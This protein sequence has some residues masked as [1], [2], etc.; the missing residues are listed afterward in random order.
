[1]LSASYCYSYDKELK[2]PCKE[3]STKIIPISQLKAPKPP[4]KISDNLNKTGI[5]FQSSYFYLNTPLQTLLLRKRELQEFLEDPLQKP[6][7]HQGLSVSKQQMSSIP[8]VYSGLSVIKRSPF[9]RVNHKWLIPESNEKLNN[10]IDLS[11]S[12]TK[13]LIIYSGQ[14]KYN[15]LDLSWE[16]IYYQVKPIKNSAEEIGSNYFVSKIKQVFGDNL[17]DK[18]CDRKFDFINLKNILCKFLTNQTFQQSE[19]ERLCGI[20]QFLL[21][22]ILTK[23]KLLGGIDSDLDFGKFVDL[24]RKSK[25][26]SKGQN[27]D[28]MIK[29]IF[30]N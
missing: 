18:N 27:L 28:F 23:R 26:C 21:R 22:S 5:C 13:R 3:S 19:F 29:C 12:E 7:L 4:I 1:M 30:V 16:E 24:Q 8:K 20:E 17:S 9:K 14:D 2:F 10:K 15:I 6:T 11:S 25:N